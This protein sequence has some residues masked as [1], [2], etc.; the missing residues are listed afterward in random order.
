M[1][2]CRAL[3]ILSSIFIF[4][5]LGYVFARRIGYPYDLEWMESG[6]LCHALR[7]SEGQAIYGP[8]SVDFI[9][10]LYTP[11]YP[12]ILAAIGK[13]TGIGYFVAR[14]ISILSFWVATFLGYQFARHVGG[15]RSAAL[16]AMAIP[17]AAFAPTGAFYDLAR[18]DSLCLALITAAM[19][20]GWIG[21]HSVRG[22]MFSALLM[23]A[24]FFTKQTA[25]PFMVALGL[26]LLLA[27]WRM[28][29]GYGATLALVGV[30]LLW[31]C[32]HIS[33][34]WFWTYV[35]VLHRQHLF[36]TV[37]AFVG[38]PLHLVYLTVPAL[39]VIPWALWRRRSP[40]LIFA[41]WLGLT[42]AF[43]ACL[44]FGTQWA[45]INAFIPGVFFVS[46]AIGSAAGRLVSD[47]TPRRAALVFL[48]C[49]TT[50]GIAPGG[51]LFIE[52]HEDHEWHPS[53]PNQ[54]GYNLK[55][56]LPTKKARAQGDAVIAELKRAPG[57]VLIPFHPFYAHL[58]GKKTFVHEM[59]VKDVAQSYGS[60]KDLA[61]AI[62]SKR[63]SLAI[64]DDRIDSSWQFWPRMMQNYQIIGHVDG[65]PTFS[66]AATTP[67]FALAPRK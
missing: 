28:A 30:P 52:E 24:A 3:A 51:L 46:V 11:L 38:T 44:G 1:K 58:A 36:Y 18:A 47:E 4:G 37:R 17:A 26:A 48:L 65:P 21:R 56:F 22:A 14:S 59:G 23:V 67:R 33:Q 15:S 66:G 8:P 27:N 10:F 43:S 45:Y 32:N 31:L 9:P 2:H 41:T 61:Q 5:V 6:T 62:S 7:Q 63:F 25:S 34:G 29:L 49:T 64:F 16:C 55:P 20:I 35:S 54:V 53:V 60:P 50:L 19:C 57:E 42:G 13:I 39:V 12:L 40:D